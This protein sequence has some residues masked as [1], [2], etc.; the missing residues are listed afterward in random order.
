MDHEE[1][2]DDNKNSISNANFN[3]YSHYKY[4]GDVSECRIPGSNTSQPGIPAG[5]IIIDILCRRRRWNRNA[6]LLHLLPEPEFEN[7]FISCIQDPSILPPAAM[8]WEFT[9]C[10]ARVCWCMWISLPG[11]IVPFLGQNLFNLTIYYFPDYCPYR[12]KCTP[13]EDTTT[14][15]WHEI[16]IITRSPFLSRLSCP[17]HRRLGHVLVL[18]NVCL[19]REWKFNFNFP[20]AFVIIYPFVL[21]YE[22][23]VATNGPHPA[24][25]GP[26]LRSFNI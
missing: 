12:I 3:Q 14:N 1:Q 20:A 2:K 24:A 19:A 16:S 7:S 5:P 4:S 11:G 26:S 17:G 21:Q 13:R 6:L 25:H 22:L 9:E 23:L 10:D 18:L 8:P 15:A